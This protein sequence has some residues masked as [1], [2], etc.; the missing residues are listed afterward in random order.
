MSTTQSLSCKARSQPFQVS[1]ASQTIT[2]SLSLL[3]LLT[4]GCGRDSRITE[5]EA[6]KNVPELI[7]LLK[8]QD[9]LSAQAAESL[10]NIGDKRAVDILIKSLSLQND[11]EIRKYAAEALGKIQDP[12]AAKPLV[13]ALQDTNTNVRDAS[14]TAIKE[15]AAKDPKVIK[16]LIPGLTSENQKLLDE[17]RSALARIGTPAVDPMIKALKDEN[18]MIRLGAAIVLGDIGDQKAIKPLVANLTDWYSNVFAAQALTKLDWEPQ[19][20][21][22]KIHLLVAQQKGEE[23][24]QNWAT[25]KTVLLKDVESDHYGAIQ[26]ALYAFI[27]IGDR[28]IINTLVKSL[29]EKG[30]KTMALAYLN[31][32]ESRLDQAAREWADARGYQVVKTTKNDGVQPVTWG[33]W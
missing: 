8:K 22:D 21:S 10:G 4:T 11:A 1:I 20:D 25:A 12:R 30:N 24:R 19:T 29:E 3:L 16:L 13:A 18:A 32:G 28:N 5:L 2:L 7:T 23:L 6:Q 15:L 31:C 33:G 26:N 14:K 27:S 17:T 9:S